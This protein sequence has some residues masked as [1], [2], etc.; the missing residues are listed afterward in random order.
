MTQDEID[1]FCKE[2]P[3]AFL[4]SLTDAFRRVIDF[5]KGRGRMLRQLSFD[6]AAVAFIH[7]FEAQNK[8]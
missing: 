2:H 8:S 3:A 6:P 1:K 5:R 4:D 7:N